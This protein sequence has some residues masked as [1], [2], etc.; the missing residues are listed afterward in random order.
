MG[1]VGGSFSRRVVWEFLVGASVGDLVGDLVG[2]AEG[3]Q[4]PILILVGDLV[5]NMQLY[6]GDL[7]SKCMNL[8]WWA[9]LV[10]DFSEQL[11][12]LYVKN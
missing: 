12:L 1:V 3:F 11:C 8:F 2:F 7:R 6:V 10:S 4:C 9:T 5:G